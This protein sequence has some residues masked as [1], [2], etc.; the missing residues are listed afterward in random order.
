M[1]TVLECETSLKRVETHLKH[2]LELD[3]NFEI[4]LRHV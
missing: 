4:Y 2:C 3:A 1:K